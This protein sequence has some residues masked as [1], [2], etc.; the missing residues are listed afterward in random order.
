VN[1]Y[2]SAAFAFAPEV[3]LAFHQAVTSGD[4]ALTQRLL[5]SFYLPLVQLRDQV[6]GYAVSLVKAGLRLRGQ[7]VGGV[8]PPLVDPSAAHVAELEKIIA[9]GLEI[10]GA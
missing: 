4:D 6:P 7:D 1:L 2:S 9:A 8:R 10:V 5:T 3:A